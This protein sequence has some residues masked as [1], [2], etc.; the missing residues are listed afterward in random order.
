MGA[1]KKLVRAILDVF[2]GLLAAT[3]VGAVFHEIF[4]L[5]FQEKVIAVTH[6]RCAMRFSGGDTIPGWRAKS[7]ATKEP[8]TLEW[9]E[10]FE[11]GSVFWDIGAN[12]GLY[13]V[14]AGKLFES[15]EIYAFEPS[16]FNL[17]YL[18]RNLDLN[19]LSARVT[20][21]SNPLSDGARIGEMNFSSMRRGGAIS[22]FGTL[23]SHDGN[24][25]DRVFSYRTLSSSID[26]MI[27]K[28]GL[29]IPN[30]IKIDVDGIEHLILS[31][32][33]KTLAAPELKSILVEVNDD[34]EAQA[35]FVNETLSRAGFELAE[36][37]HSELI[38]FHETF[39]RTFNQI[40]RKKT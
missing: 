23:I 1:L 29:A 11:D 17:E 30:N 15:L 19:D 33:T 4:E 37:R 5:K 31:G 2:A 24:E 38:D 10:G 7:F 20:V 12:V 18:S 14:Y 35:Q 9:I 21:I 28:W 8:E 3:K 32:A 13:S 16:V 25:L 40:W 34:F 6:R 36:K 22:S 39:A 27:E 26:E